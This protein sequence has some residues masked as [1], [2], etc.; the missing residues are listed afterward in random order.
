MTD[1]R[2]NDVRRVMRRWIIVGLGCL[3]VPLT[4]PPP[5]FALFEWLDHLSGP[6]PFRGAEFQFRVLCGMNQPS[7]EEA[8][9]EAREVMALLAPDAQKAGNP[10]RNAPPRTIEALVDASYDRLQG[11]VTKL[12][13]PTGTTPTDNLLGLGDEARRWINDAGLI[14]DD[15]MNDAAKRVRINRLQ[16][17]WQRASD[18]AYSAS[19]EPV[20]KSP[21]RKSVLG[22]W[23]NCYDGPSHIYT[24]E[25]PPRKIRLGVDYGRPVFSL[26]ANYR[27]YTTNEWTLIPGV[28]TLEPTS[29]PEYAGGAGV[30]LHMYQVQA[31]FPLTG[32]LD[33]IDGQTSVGGYLFHS[34]GFQDFGGVVVEPVRFDLHVPARIAARTNNMALRG[35]QSLSLRWGLVMFPGGIEASRFNATGSAVGKN[36]SGSEAIFDYGIV[37]NIN[38]LFWND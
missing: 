10:K 26:N 29:R 30:D 25:S 20:R 14:L 33:L 12:T 35:L 19:I 32:R 31:S 22:L 7:K 24:Q 5:A 18:S 36:V 34:S 8:L 38:R 2:R 21:G 13:P 17:Q 23:A 3:A 1:V 11:L 27:F 16:P 28:W 15:P 4:A 37:I 6:G 9:K